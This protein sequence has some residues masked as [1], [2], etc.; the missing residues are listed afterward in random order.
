MIRMKK[1]TKEGDDEKVKQKIAWMMIKTK[2][3]KTKHKDKGTQQLT[4]SWW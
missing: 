1:K 4:G 2:Q 3:N